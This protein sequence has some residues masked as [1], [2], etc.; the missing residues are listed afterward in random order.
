M[1]KK[2]VIGALVL[3]ALAGLGLWAFV[4][5]TDRGTIATTASTRSDDGGRKAGGV[6]AGPSRDA[7]AEAQGLSPK[8]VEAIREGLG[9]AAAAG[10]APDGKA[11]ADRQWPKAAV[12]SATR[13]C[14][15]RARRYV[16][17]D[18]P[19]A[20]ERTCACVVQTLQRSF[21][22]GPPTPQSKRKAIK[23]YNTAEEAAIEECA[24]R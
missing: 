8:E 24:T 21:P 4:L 22:A 9:K 2:V 14:V 3:V 5:R 17:P 13:S 1:N 12:E 10:A 18:Q 19:G 16:P 20:A 15:D 6:V 7:A 23:A 11:S